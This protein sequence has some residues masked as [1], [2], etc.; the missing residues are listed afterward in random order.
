[1]F[2][3]FASASSAF[4]LIEW[5]CDENADPMLLKWQ[6]IFSY[7]LHVLRKWARIVSGCLSALLKELCRHTISLG[8]PLMIGVRDLVGTLTRMAPDFPACHL[9]EMDMED[10]FWRIKNI[11]LRQPCPPPWTV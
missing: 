2:H 5:K 7:R 11:L 8:T 3:C 1:M 10:M 9:K 4:H 6:D